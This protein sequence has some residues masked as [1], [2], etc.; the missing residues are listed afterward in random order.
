MIQQRQAD[1]L[2]VV[3]ALR[4]PGSLA[5][6]LNSRQQQGNQHANDRDHDQQLDERKCPGGMIAASCQRRFHDLFFLEF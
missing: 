1:L 5:G 3:R 2:Q 4:T 6:R